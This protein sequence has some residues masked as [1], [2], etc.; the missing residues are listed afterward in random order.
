MKDSLA[1]KRH[2]VTKSFI[3]KKGIV[4]P[5]SIAKH[6]KKSMKEYSHREVEIIYSNV[7]ADLKVIKAKLVYGYTLKRKR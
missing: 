2:K 3:A 1:K 5:L 7:F 6:I 4:T